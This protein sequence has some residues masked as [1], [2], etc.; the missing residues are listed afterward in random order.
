MSPNETTETP[1]AAP[2][3]D[4]LK[5]ILDEIIAKAKA[6]LEDFIAKSLP[7][8]A[9]AEVKANILAPFIDKI[10]ARLVGAFAP[11]I[12]QALAASIAQTLKAGKGPARRNPTGLV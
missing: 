7:A 1:T 2:T 10:T 5:R 8:D 9:S 11:D 6:E 3:K 4:E 12:L